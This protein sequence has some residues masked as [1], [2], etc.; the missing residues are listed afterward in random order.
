MAWKWLD[1]LNEHYPHL[2]ERAR[3]LNKRDHFR[4]KYDPVEI[5]RRE[6]EDR[7]RKKQK[8]KS[9]DSKS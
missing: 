5:K 4:M 8:R 2:A 1:Q 7:L 3:H 9:E 6:E